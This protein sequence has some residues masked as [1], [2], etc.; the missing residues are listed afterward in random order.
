MKRFSPIIIAAIIVFLACSCGKKN[1][2]TETGTTQAEQRESK[3]QETEISTEEETQETIPAI[4]SNY[5][6]VRDIYGPVYNNL[7]GLQDSTF[8]EFVLDGRGNLVSRKKEKSYTYSFEYN[9]NRDLIR[10]TVD[11]R[12]YGIEDTEFRYNERGMLEEVLCTK[13]SQDGKEV[14]TYGE[15]YIY[16]DENQLVSGIETN[17]FGTRFEHTYTYDDLGR[18]ARIDWITVTTEGERDS[19]YKDYVYDGD[20]LLFVSGDEQGITDLH[21]RG[22]NFDRWGNLLDWSSV[23]DGES[24]KHSYIKMDKLGTVSLKAESEPDL[25]TADKW[26]LFAE[27]P[28]PMPD[29]CLADIIRHDDYT[30][31]LPYREGKIFFIF[32]EPRYYPE[33]VDMS[34]AQNA[35][36]N[37]KAILE[38]LY[39]Y[40]LTG[41]GDSILVNQDGNTIAVLTISQSATDGVLLKVSF[42]KEDFAK[43]N[44]ENGYVVG[45]LPDK[46]DD[47]VLEGTWELSNSLSDLGERLVFNS[48]IVEYSYFSMSRMTDEKSSVGFYKIENNTVTLN[49][50]NHETVLNYKI[51][52]QEPVLGAVMDSGSDAGHERIYRKVSSKADIANIDFSDSGQSERVNSKEPTHASELNVTITSGERNALRKAHEY[53]AVM[54]F[55]AKGLKEQLE[56]EGF[57]SGEAQYAVDNCGADWYEQAK[58]K[59][60][61][62]LDIMSFSYSGLIEQLEYEGFTHQEAAYGVD[63]VY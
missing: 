26:K 59:A 50:N 13:T 34:K 61:E 45:E 7:Y 36:E 11:K 6:L 3:I 5:T 32:D 31:Q 49:I 57:S 20:S 52:H 24:D 63:Q 29:S 58:H 25:I 2:S 41:R 12:T 53:L 8:T 15:K 43:V 33:S 28:L 47:K 35:F 17:Q 60:Q 42:D 18:I 14:N 1:E 44:Q 54:S 27:R 48:G 40:E 30:Y 56:Y 16:N 22:F 10:M 37:Y 19:Y 23:D 51:E 62:Y 38:Q 21:H 9:D 4:E 39:G 55:S 46:V